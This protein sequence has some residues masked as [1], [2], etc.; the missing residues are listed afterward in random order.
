MFSTLFAPLL[1]VVPVLALPNVKHQ[2]CNLSNTTLLLP[3]NQTA[4]AVPTDAPSFVAVAVGVQNY[5]CNATALTY[6]NVGAV[7]DLFDVSCI[8]GTSQFSTIGNDAFGIWNHTSS[9]VTGQDVIKK[10]GLNLQLLGHHYYVPNPNTTAGSPAIS[11]KWDF[12]SDAEKGNAEAFVIGAKVGDLPAPTGK[13][14]VDWVQLK[15]VEGELANTVYR[16]KTKGG[17][18]PTSCTVG[19]PSL[20]VKYTAQYWL[21]GANFKR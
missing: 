4:L 12:T 2:C 20:S 3:S 11:P 17:Q 21:Y 5:T 13:N 10:L 15:K 16:V 18:P 1:L 14:D 19:D 6:S 8:S 9:S 7:A